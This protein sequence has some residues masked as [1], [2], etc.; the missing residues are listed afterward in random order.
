LD[1]AEH[2]LVAYRQNRI[3]AEPV[4]DVFDELLAELL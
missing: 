3:A 1:E 4:D 2:R